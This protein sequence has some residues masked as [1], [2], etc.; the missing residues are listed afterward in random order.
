MGLSGQV[1]HLLRP[2]PGCV[3]PSGVGGKWGEKK[4]GVWEGASGIR[5]PGEAQKVLPPPSQP[6][7]ACWAP[8]P[9]PL[10]SEAPSSL[11]GPRAVGGREE[12]ERGGEVVGEGPS[13]IKRIRGGT[14]S[15][16]PTISASGSLLGFQVCSPAF[17][18]PLL[19]CDSQGHR[20]EKKRG[21]QGGALRD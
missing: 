3:G 10:F 16:S 12:G 14:E 8:R 18:G 1:L 6:Q 13:G 2:H 17:W 4:R 21:Q 7:E 5:G 20:R 19:P 9:G 11:V 15:I